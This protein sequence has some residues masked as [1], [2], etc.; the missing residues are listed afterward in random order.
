MYE[1]ALVGDRGFNFDYANGVLKVSVFPASKANPPPDKGSWRRSGA[2]P[3]TTKAPYKHPR[4]AKHEAA[5][6]KPALPSATLHS[7]DCQSK[8][9]HEP[10][11]AD[12]TGNARQRRRAMRVANLAAAA[13]ATSLPPLPPSKP[14][15]EPTDPPAAGLQEAVALPPGLDAS[16]TKR[17]VDFEAAAPSLKCVAADLRPSSEQLGQDS[18]SHQSLPA[19][20]ESTRAR[21]PYLRAV[22]SAHRIPASPY[23]RATTSRARTRLVQLKALISAASEP[24]HSNLTTLTKITRRGSRYQAATPHAPGIVTPGSSENP[25][26]TWVSGRDPA[27]DH[28]AETI[29]MMVEAVALSVK[30]SNNQLKL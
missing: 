13:P 8:E 10:G 21:V 14:C 9:Q 19:T 7:P 18:P 24:Q 6:A 11:A 1:G 3:A 5:G 2:A 27:L 4:A 25:A 28:L 30:H 22:R 29:I 26:I 20:Y 12:A 17:R 16:S 15:A 23:A